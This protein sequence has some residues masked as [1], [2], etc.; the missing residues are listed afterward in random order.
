MKRILH[1][2]TSLDHGG[3]EHQLLLN[4]SALDQ[5][6]FRSYVCC[7]RHEGALG[8]A[9][10]ELGVPVHVLG[11]SSKWRWL[12]GIRRLRKLIRELDIDLVHTCLFEADIIGGLA[13]K[14]ER[15]P[16]I[17]TLV[18][19]AYG[20]EW[21]IDNPRLNSFKLHVVKGIASLV[22]KSSHRAH[23]AISRFVAES[24]Q[25][26]MGL[27][28]RKMRIIYR[29]LPPGWSGFVGE[30]EV[31]A[32]DGLRIDGSF[33]VLLSV[34][35]LT[36]QK[37]Q[38]Y[39]VEAMPR[40]LARFPSAKL[41]IIG[42]GFLRNQL[43]ELR[44]RLGLQAYVDFP[45]IREDI[46]TLLEVSDLFVFPSLFEGLG[47]ALME[48]AGAGKPVVASDVG[49]LP[50]VVSHGETGVLVPPR[51]P[52]ALADAIIELASDRDRMEA[53]GQWAREVAAERFD[54]GRN[55]KHLEALYE[56]VVSPEE[57]TLEQ[58]MA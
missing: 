39:L 21:L 2:I 22:Y 42:E 20:P 16:V 53:M 37:G 54:L 23:V 24:Y 19:A 50:E 6:R 57:A 31:E 43:T 27:D 56:S 36:P 13:A 48:A 47:V 45:G 17:S 26:T 12:G 5:T 40:V 9:V 4:L 55:I 14:L 1:V 18:T 38:R 25:R 3:A 52:R 49:P 30:N 41:L 44:D 29:S 33:P 11:V 10:T 8:S 7:I 58:V 28:P 32:R 34:G 35:R 46:R 15:T 51:D